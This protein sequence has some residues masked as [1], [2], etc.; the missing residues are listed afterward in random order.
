MYINNIL[1]AGDGSLPGKD[2]ELHGEKENDQQENDDQDGV[3]NLFFVR[4]EV[5][6][7]GGLPCR[8][9]RE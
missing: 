9:L 7:S 6:A 5:R 1:L 2:P 8:E 4:H 3:Q